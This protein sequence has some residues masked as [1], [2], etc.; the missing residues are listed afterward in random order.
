MF[1]Y[2]IFFTNKLEST[3]ILNLQN[4][5]VEIKYIAKEHPCSVILPCINKGYW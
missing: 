1:I 2:F 4:V 3:Q 5:I